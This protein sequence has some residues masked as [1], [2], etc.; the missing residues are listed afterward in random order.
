MAN[1]PGASAPTA[2]RRRSRAAAERAFAFAL[3]APAIVFAVGLIAYPMFMLF[4]MSV[5][6]GKG[7]NFLDLSKQ[8]LGPG[9]WV[10]VLSDPATWQSLWTS[11]VYTAGS[12]APAFAA[13][14]ATALLLN[15]GFRGRRWL[16]GLM[17]LPWAV[18]GVLVSILFLWM[19]DAS[20]GVVNYILRSLGIIT[21]DIAWL[22][23]EDT[24]LPAVII[25]TIWKSFPFFTL[26]LL[27][28]LQ[29]IPAT[30]YEAARM[31]GATR[32]RE[33][34][35]VTWP[36][37]RSA[38]VLALVLNSLWAFR[39]FDIIY[40]TTG[41]GPARATETL[42]IRA[43]LEAFSYFEMARA[44]V[45]GILMLAIATLVVLA[46]RRPVQREFF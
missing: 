28:A 37:I 45:L 20:Y 39:E 40:A 44:S 41:G 31:D 15:I 32:Y 30:L 10:Q 17:L 3:L 24:A 12:M 19:L 4:A 27:A 43:Y 7:L 21:A 11:I 5:H 1:A 46:A 36:G 42:G 9:S 29:S 2:S 22:S 33:F 13:G 23:G 34:R 14:L 18:P 16:R 8:P 6:E 25:A 26:T 35:H 38:A